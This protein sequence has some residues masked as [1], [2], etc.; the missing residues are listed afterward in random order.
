MWS[1]WWYSRVARRPFL[2]DGAC[3]SWVSLIKSIAIPVKTPGLSRCFLLV[4]S[5]R[6]VF[7]NVP[8]YHASWAISH[9]LRNNV[10][11]YVGQP[12]CDLSV[13]FCRLCARSRWRTRCWV[14]CWLASIEHFT[15][16]TVSGH[17]SCEEGLF[18]F[19][20]C[21]METPGIESTWLALWN[22]PFPPLLVLVFMRER[23]AVKEREMHRA[24]LTGK[25]P[26]K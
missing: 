22:Q 18:L 11:C 2:R 4:L 7:V 6:E 20:S 12:A 9:R 13:I 17:A 15:S 16:L 1:F 8:S 5:S 24:S 10:V 25:P 14:V 19:S 26:H 21:L 3:F 23:W